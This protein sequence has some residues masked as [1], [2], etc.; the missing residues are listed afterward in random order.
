MTTTGSGLTHLFHRRTSPQRCI[1]LVVPWGTAISHSSGPV[2]LSLHYTTPGIHCRDRRYECDGGISSVV[3]CCDTDVDECAMGACRAD[4]HC[5]NT[6][7]SFTCTC[8][9]GYSG[10]GLYCSGNLSSINVS[11]FSTYIQ[12]DISYFNQDTKQNVKMQK[13]HKISQA[14]R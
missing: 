13:N 11:T 7:G 10:D 14:A 9:E 8:M 3:C 1:L 4:A 2:R 12:I 6:A 5:S